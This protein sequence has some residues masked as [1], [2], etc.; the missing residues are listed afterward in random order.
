VRVFINRPTRTFIRLQQAIA[1]SGLIAAQATASAALLINEIDSDTVNSPTTDAFEFIEL[2]NTNGTIMSLDGYVLVFFNGN[3][4]VPYRAEDLD[5]FSTDA[6]GYFLAGSIAGAQLAIP[7]N[8]IQNG[9]DAVGLY[10]GNA[11][12][13]TL[14]AGGTAP[15]KT[16]LEDAVVYKTGGDTDG[17]GLNTALLDAGFVL[18][19][20]AR[21]G[22]AAQG[23]LD[24]LG[25]FANGSGAPRD[26]TNW[27]YMPPTPG[28]ANVPEPGSALLLACGAIGLLGARHRRAKV[29]GR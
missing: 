10:L 13:F 29:N 21:D 25:R 18:D 16:N 1:I 24:S 20:F 17:V 26:T 23:A 11:V 5:G 15:S 3:G 28:F 8:T 9:V 6:N 14:G 12:D 27:T 2:F 4:N 22:T 7:G 19:E